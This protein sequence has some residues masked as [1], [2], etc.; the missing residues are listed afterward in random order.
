M[1]AAAGLLNGALITAFAVPPFIV[2]LGMMLIASGTRIGGRR[3]SRSTTAGDVRVAWPGRMAGLPVAWRFM[4]IL[5]VLAH[6]IMAHTTLWGG[7]STRSAAILRRAAGGVPV[8][9][10]LLL[11]LRGVRGRWRGWRD[12]LMASQLRSGAPTYGVM[13]ELYV[14]AAVVVGGRPRCRAGRVGSSDAGGGVH[15]SR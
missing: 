7:T 13:Y 11:V 8:R 4:A 14:I 10:V 2:T 1:C 12:S 15:S 9:R 3:G 5:Y 6:V